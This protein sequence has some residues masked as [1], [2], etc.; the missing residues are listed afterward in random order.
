MLPSISK[1]LLMVS[2][3]S[4]LFIFN[5]DFNLIQENICKEGRETHL[6]LEYRYISQRI[7]GTDT[8]KA[9]YECEAIVSWTLQPFSHGCLVGETHTW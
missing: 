3:L 6:T 8:E 7:L 1:V 4:S 2:Q 9:V 5:F